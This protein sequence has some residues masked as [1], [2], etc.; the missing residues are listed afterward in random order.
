MRRA[1]YLALFLGGCAGPVADAPMKTQT[2]T[3]RQDTG[4]GWAE[5]SYRLGRRHGR[6]TFHDASGRKVREG[7]YQ[8]GVMHGLWTFYFE[9]GDVMTIRYRNGT[10]VPA[11]LAAK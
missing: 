2:R 5:G 10:A 1:L 8:L 9:N 7:D 6:W 3:F 11:E 4:A